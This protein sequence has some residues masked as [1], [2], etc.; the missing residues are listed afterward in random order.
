MNRYVSC[1]VAL[2]QT[3]HTGRIRVLIM[4]CNA[5]RRCALRLYFILHGFLLEIIQ[6]LYAL[7][8]FISLSLLDISNAI[9]D[10]VQSFLRFAIQCFLL[11]NNYQPVL[12]KAMNPYSQRNIVKIYEAFNCRKARTLWVYKSVINV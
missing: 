3:R 2:S 12:K 8:L 11:I 9:F 6:T 10:V 7:R 1:N 4:Q 5:R